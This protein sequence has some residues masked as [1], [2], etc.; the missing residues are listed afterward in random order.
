[1]NDTE[2]L[3]WVQAN[4]VKLH[5]DLNEHFTMEWINKS[6]IHCDTKGINLRDCIRGAM[7]GVHEFTEA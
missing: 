2:M 4:M 6:G 7:A 3:N 1:M 5:M